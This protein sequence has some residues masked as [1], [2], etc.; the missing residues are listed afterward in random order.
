MKE[1]DKIQNKI[2]SFDNIQKQVLK[3]REE[4]KKIVFTN[5]CFDIIHRGHVDYLSKAKDLGDILIIGLNTDQSVRNIKG[6]TRPIQDENSR[7][8]ILASM[9]FVDAIV[10]FSEP[11]PYTLIKEIQPDILVKGA[12]YKKEDIV[13]YDIVSQRGGKV[14]T[15]EFIEGYSTSNIERK[16]KNTN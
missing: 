12:D 10:F 5:G 4:N 9:Q 11:T 13:G 8:I 6:N 7:A 2:I 14:E 3:W 16:I 15:I 1:L